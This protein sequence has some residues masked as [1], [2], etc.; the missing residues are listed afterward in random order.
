MM[1]ENGPREGTFHLMGGEFTNAGSAS[2]E[3]KSTLIKVGVEQSIV[4]RVAIAAFEAEMNVIIHAVAGTLRYE[5]TA[6]AVTII[7]TDMGPGI[8][9]INQAM[10]PGYST[11]PD[12]VREMGWGAGMGLPNISKHSDLFKIDSVVGEGT[13]LEIIFELKEKNADS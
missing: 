10:Q 9:N 2:S 7:V 12:W 11:A 6:E 13:T 3:L 4:R 5:I 8:E 1:T